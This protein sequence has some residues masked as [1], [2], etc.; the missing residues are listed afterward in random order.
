MA[1]ATLLRAL[2]IRGTSF[3]AGAKVEVVD[4]NKRH[5]CCL[6]P[7]SRT[8]MFTVPMDFIRI[9]HKETQR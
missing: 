1:K 2:D 7:G 3:E 8:R 4:V 9:E 5:V 6:V